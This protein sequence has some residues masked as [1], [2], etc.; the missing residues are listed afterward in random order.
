VAEV[1]G[2]LVSKARGTVTDG[3]DFLLV[4]LGSASAGGVVGTLKSWFGEQL[5]GMTDEQLEAAIGF[6]LWYFG[7]RIHPRIVPFGFGILVHGA[8]KLA[9]G[10]VEGFWSMLQKK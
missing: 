8:G 3:I 2:G 10:Y 5:A 1:L 4:I 6:L 7:D 9:E